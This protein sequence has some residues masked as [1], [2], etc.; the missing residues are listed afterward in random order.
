MHLRVKGDVERGKKCWEGTDLIRWTSCVDREK[1]SYTLLVGKRYD[2]A[3]QVITL[4]FLGGGNV[5]S[6]IRNVY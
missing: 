5:L 1:W 2:S 3:K 4:T 6:K